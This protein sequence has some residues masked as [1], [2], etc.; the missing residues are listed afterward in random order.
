MPPLASTNLPTWRSVRPRERPL[1]VAEQGGFDQVFGNGA[2]VDGDEGLALAV[3][4]ALDGARQN[5][6]ADAGLALDEDRDVGLGGAFGEPDDARHVAALGGEVAKAQRPRRTPAHAPHFAFEG[7]DAE[8]VLDRYLQ[9]LGADGLDDEVEGPR[10][11]RRDDRLDRAMGSLHD[12]GRLDAALAHLGDQSETVELRHDEVD[13]REVDALA[14]GRPEQRQRLVPAFGQN[15]L[16]AEPPHH[17][18]QKPP[19][20]G[21]V[22]DD[23]DGAGHVVPALAL[24]R[25]GAMLG[26]RSKAVLNSPREPA[27]S[28]QG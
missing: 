1:L 19:L 27:A 15:R 21:I 12:D 7:V 11:H 3:A 6:L 4:R 26:Q 22:V 16:V 20:N 17:R 13:H 10:A 24:F 5:F 2:A 18:L 28:P 23:E 9:A 14:L 8:R 25:F